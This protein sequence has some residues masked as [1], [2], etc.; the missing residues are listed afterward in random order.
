MK[1]MNTVRAVTAKNQEG[2]VILIAIMIMLLI[3]LMG[4]T[5]LNSTTTDYTITR[6]DRCFKQN[7][8]RA[9]AAAF[10]AGQ[11][12]EEDTDS[13]T[14]LKPESTAFSWLG[15]GSDF[16]PID[17]IWVYTG[18]S[19]SSY[20][21]VYSSETNSGFTAVFEGVATG[22]SLD[23]SNETQLWQYQVYGRAEQCDGRVDMVMGYRKRY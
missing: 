11:L 15:D 9:E 13:D 17:D 22:S 12:M 2:S 8:Y 14:N 4:M 18:S 5:S 3:T 19:N 21:A 16:N 6:N 10:E 1:T 7:V 20:S 23:M